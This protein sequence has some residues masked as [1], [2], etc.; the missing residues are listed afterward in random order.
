MTRGDSFTAERYRHPRKSLSKYS[1]IG[2]APHWSKRDPLEMTQDLSGGRTMLITSLIPIDLA[3][4]REVIL[5]LATPRSTRSR[6]YAGGMTLPTAR[7]AESH[8]RKPTPR[9]HGN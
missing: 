3:P 2:A 6:Y 7:F 4:I 8:R 5:L 1:A 9:P